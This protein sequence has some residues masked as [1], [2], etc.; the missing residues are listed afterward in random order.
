MAGGR[1][2][3][4]RPDRGLDLGLEWRRTWR[5]A[6]PSARPI[7]ACS[8]TLTGPPG[9]L[10]GLGETGAH[11]VVSTAVVLGQVAREELF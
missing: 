2:H 7:R 3:P 9:K 6:A 11:S 5:F 1:C 10:A 8:G 4:L